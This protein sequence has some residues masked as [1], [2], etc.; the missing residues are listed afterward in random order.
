MSDDE[1]AAALECSRYY[2]AEKIAEDVV[3]FGEPE[4][5]Q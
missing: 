3:G 2:L 5:R 1:L 4:P